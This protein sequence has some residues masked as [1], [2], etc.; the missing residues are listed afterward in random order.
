MVYRIREIAG[1]EEGSESLDSASE[2]RTY[3]VYDD[4]D[5]EGPLNIATM[6]SLVLSTSPATVGN[7]QR[8]NIAREYDEAG[9]QWT[10]TVT[11]NFKIPESVLTW[12]FDTQAGTVN[13]QYGYTRR[14]GASGEN[15]APNYNGGIG[16]SNGEFSGVEKIVPALKL[17]ARYRWPAG[18]VTTTYVNTIAALTGTVNN[19]VWYGYNAGELLFM[20]ASGEII[21]G[22]PTEI[23]YHFAASAN[24]TLNFGAI[25]GVVKNGHEYL[26][27]A[28]ED[29]EDT[30]EK[31]LVKNMRGAYVSRVYDLAAFTSLGIGS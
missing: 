22:K 3:A 19:A 5:R 13:I 29:D 20:G 25:T 8:D 9:R 27:F 14:W 17:N 12:G 4:S 7:L 30:A 15:S 21:P 31:R 26:W 6:R 16:Y 11:Y 2:S 1:S 28:W 24:A 23:N 18:S 10:W